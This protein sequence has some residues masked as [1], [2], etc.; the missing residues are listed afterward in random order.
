MADTGDR[1]ALSELV[2]HLIAAAELTPALLL[3]GVCAG[4]VSLLAEALAQLAG[5]DPDRAHDLCVAGPSSALDALFRKARL[6]EGGIAVFR[7]ALSVWADMGLDDRPGAR[8]QFSRRMLE[9]VLTR[10]E[11]MAEDDS[12]HLL[13]M[14][15]R[16][17]AEAARI[18][19]RA[20]TQAYTADVA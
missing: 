20:F 15:R 4:N 1:A 7:A 14:L 18:E 11:G 8:A 12:D 6:P 13:L 19:A 17:A 16:F 3:R 2:A 10:Y 5:V 9:R